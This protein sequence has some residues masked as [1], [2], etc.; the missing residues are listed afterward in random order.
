MSD[1]VI[2]A[3]IAGGFALISSLLSGVIQ[4]HRITS[5][6]EKHQ[7]VTDV[8][9][10]TLTD[11]VRQHNNFAVKIPVL[12]NDIKQIRDEIKEMRK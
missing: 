6:L 2:A 5:Q 9:I 10:Q 7:A 11:E 8:K 1:G 3:I 12:E 4:G